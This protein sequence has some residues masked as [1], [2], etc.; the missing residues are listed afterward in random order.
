MKT[1]LF[2]TLSAGIVT[3]MILFVPSV[4]HAQPFPFYLRADAGGNLTEDTRLRAF[5][6]PVSPGSRVKFDP[7][8]RI[9]FAG[10]LR[11][12]EWFSGE[13]EVG[14]MAN[15]IDFITGATRVDATFSNVPFLVNARLQCPVRHRFAPYIGVGAGGSAAGITADRI[16]LD[17]TVMDGSDATVVFAYQ[18]FGGVRYRLND[19]MGLSLEYRYFGTTA[20]EWKAEVVMGAPGD[21]LRFGSIQTHAFSVAFDWTF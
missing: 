10:G 14:V 2:S 11:M 15:N 5:F 20:P 21:R 12:T 4:G 19:T 16:I 6:G 3:A 17:G 9:G 7:G 1:N 18:A 13:F 8:V